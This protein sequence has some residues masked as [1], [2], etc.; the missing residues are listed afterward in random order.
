VAA[1]LEGVDRVY[2]A[3]LPQT[4]REVVAL[5]RAAGVERI[6]DLAGAKETSWYAVEEAVEE[7]GLAWTHLEPGEFMDNSLVWAEQIR[8]AG[9]VRD[10]YPDAAN[11]P[12]DLDDIA[13][14][15]TTALLEEGHTGRAY[16]LTGPETITRGERIRLIGTALGRDI[17]FVELTHDEAV[18]ERSRVM[19]EY[20]GWYLDA[21]AALTDAPQRPVMTVEDVTGRPA[22]TFA[23][24][25]VAHADRFSDNA[26]RGRAGAGEPTADAGSTTDAPRPGSAAGS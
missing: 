15:A 8:T 21:V 7:S 18:R 23:Q 22:T 5:A 11:A 16:E 12:I 26:G 25:A 3:P 6:V 24:W 9:A 17:P 1:A 10:A 2:L 19:G 20:A 4:V 13:A 14:V